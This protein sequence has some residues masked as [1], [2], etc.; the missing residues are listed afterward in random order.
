MEEVTAKILRLESDR[1]DLQ[2][3]LAF[4]IAKDNPLAVRFLSYRIRNN[5]KDL[6][7][8]HGRF[9]DRTA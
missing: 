3:Q 2:A 8:L 9:H 6:E 4:Q 5:K 1:D 7:E